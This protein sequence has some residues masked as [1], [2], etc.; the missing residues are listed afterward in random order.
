M[1]AYHTK[2]P[3]C[4]AEFRAPLGSE[5]TVET[6]AHLQL[7][8]HMNAE[9]P[10]ACFDC[11]R[12]AESPSWSQRFGHAF[13][14]ADRTCSYCGSA[15][16]ED[17]LNAVAD[18]FQV[19]PTDKNYKA[20]VDLPNRNP[21]AKRVMG[22][23][24]GD[25]RPSDKWVA[26]STL[27]DE[28]LVEMGW[29]PNSGSHRYS[30]FLIDEVGATRN[31]KFYFQH[32]SQAQRDQFIDLYNAQVMKLAYPHYFYTRPYFCKPRGE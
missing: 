24:S 13:W 23:S 30:W 5:L 10:E 20:Y 3:V 18:G 31:A 17:F 2:C 21:G 19:T 8:R 32:L 6:N 16:P 14:E 22:A 15:H 26:A 12:M 29:S 9:H 27:T 25:P 11:G 7:G 1:G 4:P 28:Q